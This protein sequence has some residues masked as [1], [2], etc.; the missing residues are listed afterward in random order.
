MERK[1]RFTICTGMFFLIIFISANVYTFY[2]NASLAPGAFQNL[3]P[4]GYSCNEGTGTVTKIC[5]SPASDGFNCNVVSTT[6]C[7]IRHVECITNGPYTGSYRLVGGC[8]DGTGCLSPSLP[9]LCPNGWPCVPGMENLC[10]ANPPAPPPATVP[11]WE[12]DQDQ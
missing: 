8:A 4:C 12:W 2:K 5:C 10:F 9:E 6:E 1:W 3:Y 7:G 11:F